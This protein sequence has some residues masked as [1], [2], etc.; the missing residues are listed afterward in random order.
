GEFA[1]LNKQETL[2]CILRHN[3]HITRE[4][5]DL[6]WD[7]DHDDWGPVLDMEAHQRKV[8]IYTREWGL[9]KKPV[10]TYYTFAFLKQALN[11]LGLLRA[12]DPA[13]DAATAVTSASARAA[14]A[15]V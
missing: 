5:A 3:T 12:W 1:R 15:T 7:Q 2:D 9:P 6:A 4:M 11:E 14:L 13:L 10:S 8:D